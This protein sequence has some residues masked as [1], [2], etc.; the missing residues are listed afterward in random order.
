MKRFRSILVVPVTTNSS[1][2]PEALREALALAETSGADVRILGH[3]PDAPPC[4][5][6]IDNPAQQLLRRATATAYENRLAGWASS[7]GAPDIDIEIVSGSLPHEVARRVSAEGHDLVV[8]AGDETAESRAAAGRILRTC[9]CP[10]WLLRPKFRGE[11]VVA[12]IDPDHPFEQNR[13]IL[14]LAASQAILHDGHLHVMHAWNFPDVAVIQPTAADL[15]REQLAELM[16]TVEAAHRQ[17]FDQVVAEAGLATEP[18]THLV[19][20]PAARAIHG[21]AVLYGADLVVLGAGSWQEPR[22]GLGS[23][24]E[25]VLAEIESSLLVARPLPLQ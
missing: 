25:Q 5:S 1:V 22:L 2:P 23:T 3:L 10:V 24:T 12:A 15:S 13:L 20:G 7:L 6:N 4:E 21:L 19:D 17:P 18:Q 9:P 8:I 14:E 16:T 11:R